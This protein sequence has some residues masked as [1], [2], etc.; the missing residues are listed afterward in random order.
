MRHDPEQKQ[1]TKTKMLEAA[2][3]EFRRQGYDGAGVDGLAKEAGVTSGAF[4]KHFGSKADA[5]REAVVLGVGEFQSAVELY[6]EKYGDDWLERFARFYLGEKRCDE[7]GNS[8][9]LQSLTPEVARAD[10]STREA[11]QQGLLKVKQAFTSGLSIESERN[12]SSEA[13]AD[14]ALLIGGVTLARAVQ[15]QDLANE[16][17]D[18]VLSAFHP[19][20]DESG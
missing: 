5:F 3:R 9:A 10:E 8:C 15:D 19:G 12:R 7:L 20:S 1:A 6:Q 13:W 18:A 11:Y 14:I 4:Y 16:I 2:H 17:T